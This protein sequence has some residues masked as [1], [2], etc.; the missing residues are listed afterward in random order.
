M[1]SFKAGK[2]LLQLLTQVST[3]I[4]PAAAAVAGG[5]HLIAF[6]AH[7]FISLA[8]G[9]GRGREEKVQNCAALRWGWFALAGCSGME[10]STGMSPRQTASRAMPQQLCSHTAAGPRSPAAAGGSPHRETFL[11][12]V[13]GSWGLSQLPPSPSSFW[14]GMGP[15]Q[16]L[17]FTGSRLFTRHSQGSK[18]LGLEPAWENL[19]TPPPLPHF[20]FQDTSMTNTKWHWSSAGSALWFK[21]S[22]PRGGQGTGSTGWAL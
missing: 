8:A 5:S 18:T 7:V 9:M 6:P 12:P 4:L 2:E 3:G 14:L 15:S 11:V 19:K 1:L 17:P 10:I 13:K 22:L 20:H 16:A 21:T